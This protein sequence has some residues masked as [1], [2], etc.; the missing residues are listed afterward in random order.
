MN[1]SI[2]LNASV[3]KIISGDEINILP[4]PATEYVIINTDDAEP[5]YLIELFDIAGRKIISD[6]QKAK[7]ISLD[8]REIDQGVYIIRLSGRDQIITRRI[9]KN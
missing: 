1:N 2:I 7:L 5:D 6:R 3:K 8:L 9:I 4:D